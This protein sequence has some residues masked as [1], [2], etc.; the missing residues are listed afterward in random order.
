MSWSSPQVAFRLHL[1]HTRQ[2]PQRP[3]LS[4]KGAPQYRHW[5]LAAGD[6]LS[7]SGHRTSHGS[8]GVCSPLGSSAHSLS[9]SGS[10]CR[11]LFPAKSRITQSPSF[12]FG[13]KPRPTI[14]RYKDRLI[15]G[16]VSATQA[17]SGRSNPSVATATLISALIVPFWNWPSSLGPVHTRVVHQR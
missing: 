4:P 1:S 13:R 11:R 6:R 3:H 5:W 12:C 2:M 17:A 9:S 10:P 14:C 15:V 8:P 7:H 16:R